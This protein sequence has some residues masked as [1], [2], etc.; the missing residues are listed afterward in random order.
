M[1]FITFNMLA[2]PSEDKKNRALDPPLAIPS[3]PA[4]CT[5]SQNV[6]A[7]LERRKSKS[8]KQSLGVDS[9]LNILTYC[10]TFLPKFNV[11]VQASQK[12]A[13]QLSQRHFKRFRKVYL[14][15]P[16]RIKRAQSLLER[17]FPMK[18]NSANSFDPPDLSVP[19]EDQRS[20]I[21]LQFPARCLRDMEGP[22]AQRITPGT[23][24][25]NQQ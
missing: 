10:I 16:A 25:I 15:V 21:L 19:K 14:D 12:K 17:R 1:Q 8:F 22:S 23:V 2:G 11:L 7:I 3:N 9:R 18:G 5:R 20:N 6:Q 13:L 24:W 4:G